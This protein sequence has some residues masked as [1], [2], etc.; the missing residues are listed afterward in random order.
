MREN[1]TLACTETGDRNYITTKNKRNNPDRIE[2][3]KYS[4]RLKRHTLHR[5]TK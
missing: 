5:E 1:I 3:M 4:P 2:L